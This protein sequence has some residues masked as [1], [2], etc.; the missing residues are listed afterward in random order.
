MN[1][2]PSKDVNNS[3]HFLVEE[4]YDFLAPLELFGGNSLCDFMICRTNFVKANLLKAEENI[5]SLLQ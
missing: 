5:K 4:Q 2:V 1:M 3:R